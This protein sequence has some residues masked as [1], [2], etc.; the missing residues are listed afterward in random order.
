MRFNGC[1][2]LVL[3]GGGARAAYQVGVLKALADLV[4][5]PQMPFRCVSGVSAGSINGLAVAQRAD[6]FVEAV[7]RLEQIWTGMSSDDV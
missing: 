5:G 7:H 2:G 1:P 4:E 3:P 6:D